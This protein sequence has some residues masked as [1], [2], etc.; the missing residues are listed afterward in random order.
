MGFAIFLSCLRQYL[1]FVASST[2]ATVPQAMERIGGAITTRKGLSKEIWTGLLN[3]FSCG[4]AEAVRA[5]INPLLSQKSLGMMLDARFTQLSGE[6]KVMLDGRH[7]AAPIAP[8][9]KDA[10]KSSGR[11]QAAA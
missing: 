9:Q 11:A 5:A 2:P 3:V 6:M 1:L 7:V 8:P 10:G 4:T